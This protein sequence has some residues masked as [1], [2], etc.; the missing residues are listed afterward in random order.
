MKT[1]E[2]SIHLFDFNAYFELVSKQR[3]A[4]VT[5]FLSAMTEEMG[6][7]LQCLHLPSAAV[8][9]LDLDSCE[10]EMKCESP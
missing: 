2:V 6:K 1:E 8:M 3:N 7:W 5:D 10:P 9:Q 4:V